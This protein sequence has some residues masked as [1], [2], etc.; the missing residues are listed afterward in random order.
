MLDQQAIYK[1]ALAYNKKM[2]E[3]GKTSWKNPYF[4]E[5]ATVIVG[6]TEENKK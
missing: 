4:S 6:K 2:R 5:G 1:L 3:L